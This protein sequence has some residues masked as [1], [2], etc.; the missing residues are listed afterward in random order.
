MRRLFYVLPSM[1]VGG[2]ETQLARLAKGV[3]G[4]FDVTIVCTREEGG[5]ASEVLKDGVRLR[6]EGNSPW[7]GAW[8][9]FM[10]RRLRRVFRHHRPHIVHSFM[11][12][13]DYAVNKAARAMGTPVVISSRRQLATW[14]K[15][16]HVRLQRKANRLADVVVA[17]SQAVADFAAKQEGLSP[18]R[19]RVIHNGIH[20]DNYLS[21][22][23][24][25]HIRDRFKLPLEGPIVGMVANF[26]PVKNH[27]L[28]L[29]A[30]P[31]VIRRHP[32]VHF[33]LLG[34]GRLRDEFVRKVVHSDLEGRFT[35][36][37]TVP[38]MADLLRVMSVSVLCSHIEGF[39]NAVMEAMAAGVPV[40]AP[41]VGGI[42]EL[43]EDGLTGTLYP[44]H[45]ARLLADALNG[46]LDAPGR[47]AA[48]AQRASESVRERFAVPRM[49]EAY[50]AL[51]EELW[52]AKGHRR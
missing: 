24:P 22:A 45:E 35:I 23:D 15:T 50:G 6:V 18:E 51:Y 20:A 13:F 34:W 33:L 38:E 4:D 28:L 25:R 16:R 31:A 2:T 32:K 14:K 52:A 39:P 1:A 8:D 46:V 11:F 41:E 43:I 21:S 40:V 37:P 48:M 19:I 44:R 26:S 5:L 49:V 12:G 29:E 36:A 27:A 47:A 17:N 10:A 30:A 7:L 9:P 42:P 3:C